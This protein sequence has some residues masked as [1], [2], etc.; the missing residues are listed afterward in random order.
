M[1]FLDNYGVG[2][3][4]FGQSL[5]D[6]YKTF[7]GVQQDKQRLALQ[8]LL[9]KA[10]VENLAQEAA[11]RKQTVERNK[12]I[13]DA[14]RGAM[15]PKMS[16]EEAYAALEK[17][18]DVDQ[19]F[20]PSAGSSARYLTDAGRN[21]LQ[22]LMS[23]GLDVSKAIENAMPYMDPAHL[24]QYITALRAIQI[25]PLETQ[26]KAM[27]MLKMQSEINKN[28]SDNIAT[29]AAGDRIIAY[30]KKT[31]N[32]IH[33][34]Q[35]GVNPTAQVRI[36]A[37]SIGKTLS[38]KADY[39]AAKAMIKTLPELKTD[40]EK[41]NSNLV[42]L[43]QLISYIEQGDAGAMGQLKASLAPY[44]EA[45]GYNSKSLSNAQTYQLLAKTIVG[46]MRLEMVGTGNASNWENALL[47]SVSGGGRTA[48]AAAKE[49]L[50]FYSREAMKKIN[51]YNAT[52][53]SLAEVSPKSRSLWKKIE[54][55]QNPST[56]LS[57][58]DLEYTARKYNITVDEVKRRLG[59]K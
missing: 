55:G 23:G 25:R 52:V 41:A 53:D 5:L 44:A 12:N 57:Q 36:D 29:A 56:N 47:Q 43:R 40:A 38:D 42:K 28:L 21:K 35:V 10:Q 2:A 54:Y 20:T 14:I 7:S 24:P 4:A 32:K 6:A 59:V 19:L 16:Q 58:A 26:H 8:D 46:P 34:W 3:G 18:P 17:A 13:A 33:E 49:L 22:G 39:E 15:I 51:N 1:G 11:M 48:A 31:G 50:N 45:L 27:E 37:A 9:T 30:D